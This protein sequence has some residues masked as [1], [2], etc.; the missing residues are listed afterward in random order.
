MLCRLAGDN[1]ISSFAFFAFFAVNFSGSDG[2]V[3]TAP[4][5]YLCG[6]LS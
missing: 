5:K 3:A 2:S 6:A 4:H 1:P